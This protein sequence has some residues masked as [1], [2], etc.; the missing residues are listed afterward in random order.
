[1]I[2]DVKSTSLSIRTKIVI[3]LKSLEA[4]ES[5]AAP[6]AFILDFAE[7]KS[8]LLKMIKH[9]DNDDL[10]YCPPNSNEMMKVNCDSFLSTNMEQFS[11]INESTNSNVECSALT[12]MDFSVE[13]FRPGSICSTDVCNGN[14]KV[15]STL[16]NSF[17]HQLSEIGVINLNRLELKLKQSFEGWSIENTR[18]VAPMISICQS[19]GSGKSKMALEL[20]K[21]HLGFYIVFRDDTDTGFPRKNQLSDDFRSIVNKYKDDAA[22]LV[23]FL[24]TS[25][26][27][28]KILHFIAK[29]VTGTI[30]NVLCSSDLDDNIFELGSRF[31]GNEHLDISSALVDD[32]LMN[33]L[34][35]LVSDG[36]EVTVE[37]VSLYI[38][39]I[40]SGSIKS[41]LPNTLLGGDMEGYEKVLTR[42]KDFPFLFT[43][44]EAELL[45]NRNFTQKGRGIRRIT[46]FEIVRR[47]ISY[48][49]TGTNILF[50]TLGTK[51][52]AIDLNPPVV[53]NSARF[54]NRYVMPFPIILSSNL[55][56]FSMR[57]PISELN[58]SYKLL[59]NSHMLKF[60]CT[61]GHS[62][63]CSLPY[64]S[65]VS[66]AMTKIINGSSESYDYVL[67]IWMILTGLSANPFRREAGGLVASN[68]AYLL[69]ISKDLSSLLVMYPSEPILAMAAH[70]LIDFLPV[71]KIF[72]KL[73]EKLEVLQFDQ[74]AA[75]ELFGGMII[76][77]AIHS[78]C[79]VQTNESENC[80]KQMCE[81]TPSNFTELWETDE[82]VLEES[83]RTKLRKEISDLSAEKQRN[84]DESHL[85]SLKMKLEDLYTKIS[86]K[87]TSYK[88]HNVKG[89]LQQLTKSDSLESTGIPE[90]VLN[91]LVNATHFV[92]LS[93]FSETIKLSTGVYDPEKPPIA[94]NRIQDRSRNVL[95]SSILKNALLRQC[96]LRMPP[97][98]YGYDYAIPVCLED[99][100]VTFI[101]IQVKR[102]N[103]NTEEDI[104]KMQ[105]RLH[106]V[107]RFK[108]SYIDDDSL[109]C[110]YYNQV[111]I[112]LSLD[113]ERTLCEFD[114]TS[115]ITTF[116]GCDDSTLDY[117]KARA[118]AD[119]Y[120]A[121]RCH[122]K[123]STRNDFL[124]PLYHE[125]EPLSGTTTASISKCIWEDRLVSI[126]KIPG[127]EGEKFALIPF[128]PDNFC[129]RQFCISIRGWDSYTDLFKKYSA[130]DVDFSIA[131]ELIDGSSLFR[132]LNKTDNEETFRKIVYDVPMCFI[133]YS[134]ELRIRRNG[135]LGSLMTDLN[136][137]FNQKHPMITRAGTIHLQKGSTAVV[138]EDEKSKDDN[139]QIPMKRLRNLNLNKNNLL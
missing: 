61:L 119:E 37:T 12:Y 24:Y 8:N 112:I 73:H 125:K 107:E 98:Y 87:L 65:C 105:A 56:I 55:N 52:N 91:G 113:S 136:R 85:N 2:V 117:L 124:K 103:A 19:S 18:Y 49:Q 114:Q 100:T 123:T 25:C 57:F 129:H 69:D 115:R 139:L 45:A 77:R 14:E 44:D 93:R 30:K 34:Y 66:T 70:A 88:V 11:C 10:Y 121:N 71:D 79:S 20:T 7:W 33:E 6:Q 46:G 38:Q 131:N 106:L 62:I 137:K 39:S 63:W 68:M 28:G 120:D 80:L 31:E 51:S 75:A 5:A 41:K 78:S 21:K 89:F 59:K 40:L 110:I 81:L 53:D 101:G 102:S 50:L 135:S 128:V 94:D 127:L 130:N 84:I 3:F 99:D 17:K 13:Y 111:S 60:L 138:C 92:N 16:T 74:G 133:E 108:N 58:V 35:G 54:I 97:N 86:D 22:N 47:A 67:P 26:T 82:H 15:I 126:D 23:N 76:L 29:I 83:K 95:D 116:N 36:Q 48:L 4:N 96:G 1:L 90:K 43:L 109:R 9:Q 122:K 42:L 134:E 27:V 64:D 72:R 132:N 104:Y 32:S 118:N